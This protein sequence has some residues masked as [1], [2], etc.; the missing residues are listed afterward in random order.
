MSDWELQKEIEALK[1]ILQNL[2]RED[3]RREDEYIDMK[4]F[5]EIQLD[6]LL[7]KKNT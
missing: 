4:E 5:Y 6:I 3:F 1:Q 2:K 7:E